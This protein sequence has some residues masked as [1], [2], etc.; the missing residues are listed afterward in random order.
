M[1]LTPREQRALRAIEEALAVEDPA[2]AKLLGRG[3]VRRRVRLIRWATWA[4]VTVAAILL[5]VALALSDAGMFLAALAILLGLVAILQWV[6]PS[7]GGK[8]RA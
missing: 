2:L 3:P 7:A 6:S 1:Q 5:L 4:A 8:R